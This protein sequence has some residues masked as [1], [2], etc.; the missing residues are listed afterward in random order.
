MEEK[1]TF[2]ARYSY[3]AV[4]MLLDQIVLAVFGFSLATASRVAKNDTLMLWASIGAIVFYMFML[5]GV[6]WRMGDE[7]RKRIRRG[8]YGGHALT[9]TLVSLLANSVN[10]LLAILIAVGTFVGVAGLVDIPK[11]IALLANGE[12]MGLLAYVPIG[13]EIGAEGEE[14]MIA[15]NNAWWVYFLLPIPAMVIST[16]GYLMGKAGILLTKLT[17]PDLPTS[18]RPTK[19]EKREAR[20]AKRQAKFDD[21]DYPFDDD[22]VK[23]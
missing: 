23:R 4:K 8:E 15:L 14:I 1:K 9:G 7:D 11:L 21:D 22:Y 18:D 5:Y 3:D 2:F 17:V 16:W 20:K 12:Y 10:F 13:T 6:A 19:E